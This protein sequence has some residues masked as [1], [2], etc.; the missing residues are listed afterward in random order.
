MM[1]GWRWF[2]VYFLYVNVKIVRGNILIKKML[3]C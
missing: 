2:K 1:S 3:N